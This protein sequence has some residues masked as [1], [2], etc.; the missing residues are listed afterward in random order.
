[1]VDPTEEL[2]RNCCSQREMERGRRVDSKTGRESE[3]ESRAE[4]LAKCIHCLRGSRARK[5]A[6]EL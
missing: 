2:C 1:M 3:R 6:V 4:L 5:Y